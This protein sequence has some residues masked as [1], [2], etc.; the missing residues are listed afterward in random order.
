M[1]YSSNLKIP[2]Y[3]LNEFYYDS[4]HT[5][6]TIYTKRDY[7]AFLSSVRIKNLPP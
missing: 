2:S 6:H 4:K 5:K 1:V 3:L 7:I